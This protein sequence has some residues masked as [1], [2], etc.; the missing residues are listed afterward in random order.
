MTVSRLSCQ[1]TSASSAVWA[2]VAV[3]CLVT[4]C[5][6]EQYD[7]VLAGGRVMD[8]ETGL[9]AVRNVGISGGTIARI[10]TGELAGAVVVD[11]SGHVVAPGFVDIHAHG[12][13]PASYKLQAQDGV[14]SVFEFEIGVD[15]VEA[16]YGAREGKTP[17]NFGVAAGHLGAR[18]AVIREAM[19]DGF[20]FEPGFVPD[21]VE[22]RS[23][24]EWPFPPELME[25]VYERIARGLDAGAIGVGIAP[26]YYVGARREEVYRA[27]KVAA[28]RGAPVSVHTRYPGILPPDGVNAVQ[29]VLADAAATGA[30][31]HFNHVHSNFN[32][33]ARVIFDML[34]GAVARGM[35]ITTESLVFDGA[36]VGLGMVLFD[37]DDWQQRYG[38]AYENMMMAETGEILTEA[39]FK[40][41]REMT[42][43]GEMNG[44]MYVKF[45]P[46]WVHRLSITHPLS[47]IASDSGEPGG[48]PRTA[49]TFGRLL[50]FFVREQQ[51]LTLMDALRK[52]TVQPAGILEEYVPSMRKKGRLQEG[53]DADITVFDPQTVINRATYMEQTLPTAGIPYVMV[54]G[55]FVVRGGEVVEGVHPGEAIKR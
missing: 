35:K 47:V 17:I 51:W 26:M 40:R 11:V 9:D 7:V 2:T 19:A 23:P 39:T 42:K 28:E 8:P 24:G 34:E 3:L 31:L 22:S 38:M 16:W 1:K 27:I 13:T 29:E 32:V 20:E 21:D 36:G 4:A 12:H 44:F 41:Y 53:A 33:N 50:G 54:N 48:H 14:T 55:A 18:R 25:R 49:G 15:S 5:A 45:Y 43:R 46:E 52:I 37:Y 10:S 6:S 30:R